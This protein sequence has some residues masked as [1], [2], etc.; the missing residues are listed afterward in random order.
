MTLRAKLI[1]D[2]IGLPKGKLRTTRTDAEMR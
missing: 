2:V 1:R